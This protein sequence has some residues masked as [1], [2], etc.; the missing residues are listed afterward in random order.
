MGNNITSGFM[1]VIG[2]GLMVELSQKQKKMDHEE[3]RRLR[4]EVV[5]A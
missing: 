4:G 1:N 2:E 3:N 5:H